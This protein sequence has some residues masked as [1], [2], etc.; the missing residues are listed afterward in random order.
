M[1]KE[2]HVKEGFDTVKTFRRIKTKISLEMKDLSPEQIMERLAAAS[3]E[4]ELKFGENRVES[5]DR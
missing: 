4:F 5:R 2:L 3:K 1:K